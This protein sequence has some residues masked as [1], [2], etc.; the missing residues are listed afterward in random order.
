MH[1]NNKNER[2]TNEKAGEL[3]CSRPFW[4]KVRRYIV[5]R[6]EGIKNSTLKDFSLFEEY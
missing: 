1:E 3:H 2:R 5:V 4:H 6:K